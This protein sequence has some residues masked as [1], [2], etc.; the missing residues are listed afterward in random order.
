MKA[1]D[2]GSVQGLGDGRQLGRMA[3]DKVNRGEIQL[4]EQLPLT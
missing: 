2:R 3:I 1:D 4:D